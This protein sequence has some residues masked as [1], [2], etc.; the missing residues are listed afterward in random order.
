MKHY[1]LKQPQTAIPAKPQTR[2]PQ[3]PAPKP[4]RK[5][6]PAKAPGGRLTQPAEV[7]KVGVDVGLKRYALCRQVD[8]SRPEPPR[9]I[10]PEAF[11][12]W[13]LEPQ[14]LARRGVICYEAGLFGFELARWVVA[15]GMECWVMAPVKRDAGNKR[16]ETDKLNAQE[17]TSRLDRYLA[18]N[19]R[20]LTVC[21]IPTRE[22]ELARQV[23]RQRQQLLDHRRALEAQGRS[24]RWQ[25]GYRPEGQT[26]WWREPIWTQV[27]AAVV[28]EVRGGLERLRAVILVVAQQVSEVEVALAKASPQELPAGLAQPPL[29]MGALSLL[30]LTREIMDWHRFQNRRQVG[31]FTGLVPSEAS[32]GESRWQGSVTKVGNPVVRTVLIEMA[33]RL[34]RHQPQCHALRRWWPI[35]H[36]R[37]QKGAA[38]RKK[39]IVA[40]ARVLAVDL[41]RLATDQTTPAQLGLR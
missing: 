34:V 14:P 26:C 36:D 30:I 17:I 19:T 10:S 24:L 5:R 6:L 22:E 15:Q 29:G 1:E 12:G 16:V 11:T 20:A 28:P 41:W 8:G 25:F 37:R 9:M 31:S 35:L 23:T 32:T 39:A 38:A 4:G 7:I 13:L 3:T 21:R 40:V 33:W 18:G 27:A 2:A